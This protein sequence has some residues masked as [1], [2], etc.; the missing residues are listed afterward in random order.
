[1]SRTRLFGK[2]RRIAGRALAGRPGSAASVG[3]PRLT[4]RELGAASAQLATAALLGGCAGED[5][6]KRPGTERI[7]V[8]GAGIAGVHCAYRLMQSGVNVTLYEA[9]SRVGGR[10]FTARDDDAYDGQVF[11]L[12]GELID[13]NHATL[14]ALAEELDIELD[15]RLEDSS[16]QTDVWF[17]AGSEVPEA[18]IVE[19]FTAVAPRFADAVAAAEEDDD[20]FAELDATPL[21]DWLD[22]NV[23]AADYPE[24]SAVL[25]AAYRGEFGLETSQQSALNLLYL[26][27][28]EQPDPFRIFG[29]SDE[30]Y[31]AREGSDSFVKR[32]AERLPVGAI[33]LETKLVA[34][35]G[36][37]ERGFTLVVENTKTKSRSEAN[38]DHVVL[39][40]P[41]S[42]LRLVDLDVPLSDL[43]RQI[44]DELGYGT[45]A[46]VMGSFETRV[47]REQHQK[48]GS[49]T[50]DLPLQQTWDASIGQPGPRGILTNFLGGRAGE[51]VGDVDVDDYYAGLL[52]DVDAIFPGSKAAYREG[53]ARRMHWPSYPQTLGS[54]TC[55]RPGQWSF[56]EQEGLREGN[57]HF[58]GEHTSADF[59]GW[60]EGGAETGAFAAAEVLSDLGLQPSEQL[61]SLLTAKLVVP[62]PQLTRFRATPASFRRRRQLLRAAHRAGSDARRSSV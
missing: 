39:A 50:S 12:G 1:M 49:V 32:L 61:A 45:N 41:F 59:Q 62:Q 38:F 37:D 46:K 51:E 13:S 18:T 15:D 34:L 11:E 57:L 14:L 28:S 60:M 19:Q 47:W 33:V 44:I 20:A 35:R 10:M 22:Q 6:G 29:D 53:S 30:R 55:Y 24:L 58:C 21:A 48:S 54:Y 26:I 17:V 27:D 16:I 31:H 52:D 9:A 5:S 3:A 56:W 25:S 40:I 36:A 7:A 2:L 8:V 42:V 4:R 23:P 43:K